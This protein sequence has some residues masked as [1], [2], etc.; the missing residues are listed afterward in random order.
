MKS[1]ELFNKLMI[2]QKYLLEEATGG[3][4][5]YEGNVVEVINNLI[6]LY[7]GSKYV[8]RNPIPSLAEEKPCI[9]E[10]WAMRNETQENFNEVYRYLNSLKA[11]EEIRKEKVIEIA[12]REHEKNQKELYERTMLGTERIEYIVDDLI[13][14]EYNLAMKLAIE[15]GFTYEEIYQ[16][17]KREYDFSLNPQNIIK[18]EFGKRLEALFG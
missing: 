14:T 3:K 7:R 16:I 11:S 1:K 15:Y 12:D 2:R 18:D 9:S 8:C 4:A 13:E 6:E 17:V 5:I 10:W